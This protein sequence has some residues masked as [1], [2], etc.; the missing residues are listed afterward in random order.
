MT[1][2]LKRILAMI[3]ACIAATVGLLALI[4]ASYE[5][6]GIGLFEAGGVVLALV[7]LRVCTL[8]IHSSAAE[9]EFRPPF[10]A[11]LLGALLYRHDTAPSPEVPPTPSGSEQEPVEESS[12]TAEPEPDE[13]GVRRRA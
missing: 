4:G 1:V 6:I 3:T 9:G 2:R 7:L 8:L 12:T 13:L 11:L 10:F 5:V